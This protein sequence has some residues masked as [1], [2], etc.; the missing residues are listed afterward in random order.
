MVVGPCAYLTCRSL[1][2]ASFRARFRKVLD[3]MRTIHTDAEVLICSE[4]RQLLEPA[5]DQGQ[6]IHLSQEGYVYTEVWMIA[7]LYAAW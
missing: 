1:L 5:R 6:V 7:P 3:D 2:G 4:H